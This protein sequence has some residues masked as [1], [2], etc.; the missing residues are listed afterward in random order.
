M[1]PSIHT[2]PRGRFSGLP[3]IGRQRFER[4]PEHAMVLVETTACLL[5]ALLLLKV[6]HRVYMRYPGTRTLCRLLF[7]GS[8]LMAVLLSALVG[9]A[10]L[11]WGEALPVSLNRV[12]VGGILGQALSWMLL[13]RGCPIEAAVLHGAS[14]VSQP[15]ERELLLLLT[16]MQRSLGRG[17]VGSD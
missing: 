9:L 3:C 1:P 10:G 13:S 14:W 8:V 4:Y 12:L 6:R 11:E 17:A 7:L 16:G 2:V 5:W 15:T